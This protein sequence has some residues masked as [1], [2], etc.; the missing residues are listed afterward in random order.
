MSNQESEKD[1]PLF[2]Y[3]DDL[4]IIDGGPMICLYSM[5]RRKILLAA[6]NWDV[7]SHQ[8]TLLEIKLEPHDVSDKKHQC[9]GWSDVQIEELSDENLFPLLVKKI[10]A[11]VKELSREKST[12]AAILNSLQRL[13][14][15]ADPSSVPGQDPVGDG[16]I[17]RPLRLGKGKMR[18]KGVR[19][20]DGRD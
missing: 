11:R 3:D 19:G 9:K 8:E 5:V 18:G 4:I 1:L 16:A 20:S 13:E 17:R 12:D 10:K 6:A 7:E 2:E 15:R 14:W